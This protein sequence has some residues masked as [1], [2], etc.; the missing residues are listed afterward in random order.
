MEL[1]V[2]VEVPHSKECACD[3]NAEG[4]TEPMIYLNVYKPEECVEFR[5]AA[6]RRHKHGTTPWLVWRCNWL[7]RCPC[8]I[9]VRVDTIEA[10]VA[11]AAQ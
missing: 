6:G 5:D 9:L 1:K 10:A 8:R 2:K 7:G 4:V 3:R 11:E